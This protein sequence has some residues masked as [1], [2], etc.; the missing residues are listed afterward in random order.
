MALI[1]KTRRARLRTR[2]RQAARARRKAQPVVDAVYERD[3]ACLLRSYPRRLVGPCFGA[4]LTPHHLRK[5][6][7]E[8]GGWTEDN[9]VTLCAAHNDWVENGEPDLAHALGLVV[10]NG[11]T[12]FDAWERMLAAGLPVTFPNLALFEEAADG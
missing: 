3:G 11:E 8:R 4:R 1:R 7:A 9:L 10:R 5:Q 2:S 6:S 12:T